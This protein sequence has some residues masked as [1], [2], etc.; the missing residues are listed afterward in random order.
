MK[1]TAVFRKAME[2]VRKHRIIKLVTTKRRESYLVSEPN[3]HT[4]KFF[5]KNVLAIEMGKSQILMNKDVY[6]G[7]SKIR[8][9]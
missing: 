2:H 3:Y 7:L 9:E 5:T 4:A 8:S 1:S 6:S